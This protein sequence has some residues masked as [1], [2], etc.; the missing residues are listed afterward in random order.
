MVKYILSCLENPDLFLNSLFISSILEIASKHNL[1]ILD[2]PFFP[3]FFS[4][5]HISLSNPYSNA[6]VS[7]TVLPYPIIFFSTTTT[8]APSLAK[9]YVVS[10]PAI[11]PPITKTSAFISW[12]SY[13]YILFIFDLSFQYNLPLFICI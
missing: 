1:Y 12:V 2:A 13:G 8:F 4:N 6:A 9:K 11:P 10:A 7:A 3:I 5:L